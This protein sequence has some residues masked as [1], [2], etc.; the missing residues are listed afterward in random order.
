M[1]KYLEFNTPALPQAGELA[2]AYKL[3]NHG[4]THLDPVYWN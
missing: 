1:T 2:S 4:L 3:K